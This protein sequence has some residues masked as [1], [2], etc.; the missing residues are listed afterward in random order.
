MNFAHNKNNVLRL[1]N[2]EGIIHG[3]DQVIAENTTESFRVQ[4]GYPMGYFWGYKT[5]GVFQN[6]AQID[7]FLA[8]GG[9]TKQGTPA[10]GDLIFQDTDENGVIDEKD[11]TYIGNPHPDFTGSLS[12][13]L[14]YKG[15]D[16]SM[17]AYGA[18]GQQIM[19]CYR[20]FSDTPND[21]YTTDVY[22]KYWTGEGSTNRYPAFSFGK[23]E[24][25]KDISDIYLEDGDYVK[26]SNVTIGYN[27]KNVWKNL[28]AS[29]LRIYVAAQNLFTISKY[30]GMDP[31]VGFGGGVSWASGID[32]GYYPSSRTFMV[33]VN[34]KF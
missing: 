11:K 17:T 27:F 12:L 33:G 31:E 30:T 21:N 34:L 23:H 14:S 26:I 32:N 28:P 1:A 19:K 16:F 2:E 3:P 25:F 15:L 18:F 5:L 4:V 8:E 22:T 20:S 13:N 10:P 24:N 29:Q 7:K 6:Q 9:A